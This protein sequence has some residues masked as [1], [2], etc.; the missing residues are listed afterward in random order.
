M[1]S[2]TRA[3]CELSA[4]IESTIEFTSITATKKLLKKLRE[5]GVKVVREDTPK[6]GE[7]IPG[8]TTLAKMYPGLNMG[9][10][11]VAPKIRIT[12]DKSL[13]GTVGM[14]P[15]SVLWHEAGHHVA[16]SADFIRGG[17]I[18]QKAIGRAAGLP[19]DDQFKI[20]MRANKSTIVK[21]EV[22][23]N[24]GAKRLMMK[25]GAAPDDVS[26]F[27]KQAVIQVRGYAKQSII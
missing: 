15:R 27:G 22:A 19:F 2:I 13:F 7:Y 9:N 11:N 14:G 10:A 16:K 1:E 26:A 18:Q 6:V 3:L 12:R 20:G 24:R 5:K 23:A 21:K 4:R 8:S 25:M 17:T